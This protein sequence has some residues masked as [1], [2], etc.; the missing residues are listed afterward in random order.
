MLRIEPRTLSMLMLG[1]YSTMELCSGLLVL[2]FLSLKD[3]FI[4]VCIC[5]S[6]LG[7]YSSCLHLKGVGDKRCL[8]QPKLPKPL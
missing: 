6:F 4:K 2:L 3:C 5:Y 1:K 7:K 8:Y